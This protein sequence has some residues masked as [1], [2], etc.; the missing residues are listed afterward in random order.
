V[1][2][3]ASNLVRGLPA[4]IETARLAWQPPLDVL[5]AI[6]HGRSYG[7]DS[8]VLGRRLP[9]ILPCPLWD[10]LL[11]RS[12]LPTAALVTDIGNDLVYGRSVDQITDWL[13]QCLQRLAEVVDRLVITRLPVEPVASMPSWRFRLLGSAMF[14]KSRLDQQQIVDDMSQLNQRILQYAGRYQA[15]VVHPRPEWYG[16]DPIHIRRTQYAAAWQTLLGCWADGRVIGPVQRSLRRWVTLWRARPAH[17]AMFGIERHRP[18]PSVR[19]P[20]GTTLSLY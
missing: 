5:A 3:G 17:W 13:E 19:F 10:E 18:Q 9:G 11:Q 1:L 20:D 4:V 15:Y 16:W 8:C 7:T 14:P 6:G 12:R 2:L